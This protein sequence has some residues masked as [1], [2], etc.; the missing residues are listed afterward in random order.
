LWRASPTGLLLGVETSHDIDAVAAAQRDRCLTKVRIS[1]RSALSYARWPFFSAA[2]GAGA[3]STLASAERARTTKAMTRSRELGRSV[4][5]RFQSRGRTRRHDR[6][7]VARPRRPGRRFGHAPF[8]PVPALPSRCRRQSRAVWGLESQRG[9]GAI[10][11]GSGVGTHRGHIRSCTRSRRKE[12]SPFP[13][14]SLMPE[15]VSGFTTYV[16]GDTSLMSRDIGH[17]WLG[18]Q[19]RL[20]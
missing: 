5:H 15:E 6:I 20:G 9:G 8:V 18:G 17:T 16:P 1:V 19:I 12:M 2:G 10:D 13:G 14:H 3:C 4:R 11:V 7:R